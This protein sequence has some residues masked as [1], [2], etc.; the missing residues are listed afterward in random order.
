[1]GAK[2][3]NRVI[4]G[5]RASSEYLE[6][7]MDGAAARP[8]GTDGTQA[9]G[10]ETVTAAEGLSRRDREILAFER[11][12]WQYAG[13]KEQAIKEMFDLSP[14]RYYQ[15]LNNVIDNP[16]ALAE[17]PLLVRRLRRL[18]ATRQKTRSARRLG[19]ET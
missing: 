2:N 7:W 9:D 5:P 4:R 13:L 18:R 15:V 19:F 17:D 6:V 1:M 16:A 11:Q 8:G 3:D 12:W 14:T 10:R